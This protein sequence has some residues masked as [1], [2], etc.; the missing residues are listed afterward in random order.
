MDANG[1]LKLSP[2]VINDFMESCGGEIVMHCLPEGAVAVYPE[3]IYLEMRRQENEP[4][5]RAASSTVFRREMRRFG[6]LSSSGRISEQGRLTVPQGFRDYGKLCP[7]E[8][9]LVVGI[10]IG[11]ELWNT[12]RW[13]AELEKMNAHAIAKGESEMASDLIMKE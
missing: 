10:E 6:A 7:G 3:S 1:R 4:A 5:A 2:R 11:I 9:I 8:N 12:E 13:N